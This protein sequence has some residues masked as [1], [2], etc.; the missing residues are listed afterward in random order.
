MQDL[1]IKF[2]KIKILILIIF[3]IPT[4]SLS[5]ILT[6]ADFI[7]KIVYDLNLESQVIGECGAGKTYFGNIPKLSENIITKER[8][9]DL[10][11][12]F[13]LGRKEIFTEKKLGK[14][15]TIENDIQSKCFIFYSADSNGNLE[16]FFKELEKLMV[17]F[18]LD[19][20]TFFK[21]NTIKNKYNQLKN[22]YKYRNA[23][24]ISSVDETLG[25]V[26]SGGL[27]KDILLKTDLNNIVKQQDQN[28]FKISWE[29]I[30]NNNIDIIYILGKDY[31]EAYKKYLHLQKKAFLTDKKA[32]K[33]NEIYYL[34]YM[35]IA[36]NLDIIQIIHKLN[37]NDYSR[38]KKHSK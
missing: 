8:L 24:F 19:K 9:Y 30:V 15:K 7:T 31:N 18:K 25:V 21:L 14:I 1:N 16:L 20:N 6:T 38:I 12:N 34:N 28:Y 29:I 32:F 36:P 3:F 13:I 11:P 35:D 26:G 10:S 2:I 33:F 27:L 23:L 37:N 22:K 5:N 17:T 4:T